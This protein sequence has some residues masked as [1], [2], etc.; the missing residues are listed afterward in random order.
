MKKTKIVSLVL[1]IGVI[2]LLVGCASTTIIKDELIIQPDPNNPI[3][4][5]WLDMGSKETLYVIENT[6]IATQYV[7]TAD[8]GFVFWEKHA[9]HSINDDWK[10][11]E[12][13]NFLTVGSIMY[14]RFQK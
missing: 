6:T 13:N 10:V 7:L 12:D 14:K 11:S 3:I 2:F 5:T 4:G 1:C 8:I 9:S